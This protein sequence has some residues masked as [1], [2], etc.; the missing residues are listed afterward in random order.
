[1][2][3]LKTSPENLSL[4]S[5]I[6]TLLVGKRT[7]KKGHWWEKISS[8]WPVGMQKFRSFIVIKSIKIV[9]SRSFS[10]ASL[11]NKAYRTVLCLQGL[12][13]CFDL[14]HQIDGDL[15]S[16]QMVKGTGILGRDFLLFGDR[17]KLAG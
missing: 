14:S 9:T 2:G 17:V 3:K 8:L 10:L 11:H 6:F 1:M 12:A 7:S 4:K 5:A 13:G 16:H 15:F